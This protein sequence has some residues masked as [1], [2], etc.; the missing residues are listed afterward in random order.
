MILPHHASMILKQDKRYDGMIERLARK[1]PNG[2]AFSCRERAG[3]CLQNT[4]DLARA[5]VNCNAVLDG[6][7]GI[8]L[9][10]AKDCA[11]AGSIYAVSA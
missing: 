4:N 7:L 6:D 8:A 3:R 10:N 9:P 11:V 1:R 5:A 2:L